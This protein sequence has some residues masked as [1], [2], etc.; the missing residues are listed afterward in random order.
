MVLSNNNND[1][2]WRADVVDMALCGDSDGPR[3]GFLSH[4][5]IPA[6]LMKRRLAILL[7]NCS[8]LMLW[9]LELVLSHV[10]ASRIL[11]VLHGSPTICSFICIFFILLRA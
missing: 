7:H 9:L 8:R 10:I 2:C 1:G 5:L 11:T 3:A 6:L 4:G